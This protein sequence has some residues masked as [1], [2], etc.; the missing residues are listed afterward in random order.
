MLLI[1]NCVDLSSLKLSEESGISDFD[2]AVNGGADVPIFLFFNGTV[3]SGLLCV[4]VVAT[5][6]TASDFVLS[7]AA[8]LA[9]RLAFCFAR[10][11]W[12]AT[13]F[14]FRF[15]PRFEFSEGVS[16]SFGCPS[17]LWRIMRLALSLE[18]TSTVIILN[19]L[20]RRSC[21]LEVLCSSTILGPLRSF[22]GQTIQALTS[23]CR[24]TR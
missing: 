19:C 6:D 20:T 8:F 10:L 15:S 24:D 21:A 22:R 11:A 23:G 4:S 13:N 1:V 9:F 14:A 7:A 12:W 18:F 3:S 5:S 2:D 16:V 17:L